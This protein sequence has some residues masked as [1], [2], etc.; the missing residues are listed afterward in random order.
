MGQPV[1]VQ[2][3]ADR[4]PTTW[5]ATGLANGLSIDNNG[6]ISGTT[7]Y[8]GSFNATVT[9]SNEDGNHSKSISFTIS[10]G[11]RIITW[12]EN[13]F[14]MT[15]GDAPVSLAGTANGSGDFNYTSTTPPFSRLMVQVPS[16]AEV[17]RL[18]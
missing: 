15:Y 9:A 17:E 6:I 8:I 14:G 4:N 18:R 2:I 16:F 3:G 1:S 7:N 11:N 12:D 10:K 5:T 13:F